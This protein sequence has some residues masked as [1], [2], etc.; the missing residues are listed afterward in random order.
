MKSTSTAALL[1]FLCLER[2][3]AR[4]RLSPE[5]HFER[6]EEINANEIAVNTNIFAL[7]RSSVSTLCGPGSGVSRH[8]DVPCDEDVE[9][10]GDQSE[11][12]SKRQTPR[13]TTPP[14]AAPTTLP[15]QTP[16]TEE[17]CVSDNGVYGLVEGIETFVSYNY[18]MQTIAD[19]TDPT[20]ISTDVL[21]KLEKAIV[22]S[23]L[24]DLFPQKCADTA[25]G[26]RSLNEGLDIIGV[27]MNPLD[28]VTDNSKFQMVDV[29]VILAILGQCSPLFLYP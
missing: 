16:K 3:F 27:S 11:S 21:P 20:R 8:H 18:E 26:K 10:R 14:A 25:I 5:T 6:P 12:I 2:T 22:D 19:N 7:G 28:I 17:I 29:N 9:S 1:C 15:P 24:H 4:E 13:E 23:M